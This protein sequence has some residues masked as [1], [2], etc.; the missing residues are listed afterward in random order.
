M[1]QESQED[2]KERCA[3]QLR[4][5]VVWFDTAVPSKREQTK[6]G[7]TSFWEWPG[8]IGS[9]KSSSVGQNMLEMFSE[10]K[11]EMVWTC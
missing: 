9:G 1:I 4:A 6:L 10:I 5:D 11:P 2:W 3:Q 8:L 7:V